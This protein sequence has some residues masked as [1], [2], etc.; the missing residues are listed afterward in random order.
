MASQI[1]P[2][3]LPLNKTNPSGIGKQ[4][5][6]GQICASAQSCQSLQWPQTQKRDVD[7]GSGSHS[8]F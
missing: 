7:K 2:T 4:Q 6:L 8:G 5:K 1:F 3:E